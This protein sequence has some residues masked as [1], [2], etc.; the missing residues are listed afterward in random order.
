[1]E[2]VINVLEDELKKINYNSNEVILSELFLLIDQ[3]RN[4]LKYATE[5]EIN[6]AYMKKGTQLRED[7]GRGDA[8]ALLAVNKI[9]EIRSRNRLTLIFP[10]KDMHT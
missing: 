10:V 9:R 1:M 5:D 6:H 8:L 4:D 3:Y 2:L 7:L